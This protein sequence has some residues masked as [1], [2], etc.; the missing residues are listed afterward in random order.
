MTQP[1]QQRHTFGE[2]LDFSRSTCRGR[3]WPA[4]LTTWTAVLTGVPTTGAQGFSINGIPINF[5][6]VVP[7]D[8]I[9][10]IIQ[11]LEVKFES[12][13]EATK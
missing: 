7:T 6:A 5:D 2:V 8:T 12:T 11:G 3:V 4:E 1:Q 9:A 13:P 10:S